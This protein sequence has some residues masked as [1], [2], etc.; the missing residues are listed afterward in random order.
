MT[1]PLNQLGSAN[2]ATASL[3]HP[4]HTWRWVIKFARSA[5]GVRIDSFVAA[6]TVLLYGCTSI[7]KKMVGQ[8]DAPQ[9]DFI[10]IKKD[11]AVYWSPQ[12]KTGD[13]LTFVGIVAPD[14]YEATDAPLVV[15]SSSPF[16]NSG[17][18]FSR[19]YSHVTVEWGGLKGDVGKNRSSE[20]GRQ[21]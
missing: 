20:Y 9:G 6:L 4:A 8:F 5:K 7:P 11:G 10:V 19:G 18:T 17:I 1:T 15:P 13:K 12:S 21:K 2:S 16:L 3:F 14:N